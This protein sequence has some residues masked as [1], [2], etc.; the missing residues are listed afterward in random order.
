MLLC[1]TTCIKLNVLLLVLAN[2][3]SGYT[4]YWLIWKNMWHA[5]WLEMVNMTLGG[6]FWM[7]V[8]MHRLI[9]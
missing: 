4:I 9:E 3:V 2:K 7:L 8:S 1:Y 6:A 5:L